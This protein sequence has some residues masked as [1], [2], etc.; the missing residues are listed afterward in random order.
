MNK[1]ETIKKIISDLTFTYIY[2]FSIIQHSLVLPF[3]HT[4][5]IDTFIL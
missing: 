1:S 4:T 2:T 5:D 3:I